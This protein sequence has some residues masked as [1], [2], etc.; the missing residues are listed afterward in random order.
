[1]ED[2][3][4]GTIITLVILVIC[5]AFFSAAETAFSSLNR[6]RL[7]SMSMSGDKKARR[8]LELS[9]NYDR[10]LSTVLIGNNIV[11]I[12]STSMATVLF[13]ALVGGD[14]GVTLS[15]VVMTVVI[16][17]FGEISQKA[18]PSRTPNDSLSSPLPS[19]FLLSNFC[20]HWSLFSI[21]GSAC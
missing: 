8:A 2:V 16:L 19:S 7:K 4:I 18:W 15:T 5:S 9:D 12:L 21:C 10:L 20:T 6:T 17:I 11:N 14:Y 1:M 13:V 3:R